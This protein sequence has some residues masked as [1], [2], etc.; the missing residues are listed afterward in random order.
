VTRRFLALGDSYTIGEGVDAGERWPAQ[1]AR[2]VRARGIALADPEIVAT[3]G[4][5]TDELS[6]GIA[7]AAPTPPFDL[8]S[9][10]VGVND[11]YRG[12]DVN[13]YREGLLPLLRDGERFAGGE[14]WRVAVLSI[15]DW[16]ATPF[17]ERDPRGRA[18]IAAD[19]DQFNEVAR[20]EAAES[21]MVWVDV[22]PISRRAALEPALLAA[23]KLHPSGA[24]YAEW[25]QSILPVA[26]AAFRD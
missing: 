3:T 26:L 1:L 12:R 19:I 7:R 4:W 6:A 22:T 17:A 9:L 5:T 24:M 2:A 16:S 8:V 13:E 15:P 25:V 21:G 20:A 11:Q 23:D 18:A 14:S 10:L